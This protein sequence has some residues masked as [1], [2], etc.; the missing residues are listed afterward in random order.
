MPDAAGHIERTKPALAE[1]QWLY[2]DS[3]AAIA[4]AREAGLP[5]SAEIVTC[6]PALA[7]AGAARSLED[8]VDAGRIAALS[9]A[10]DKLGADLHDRLRAIPALAPYAL[11]VA[12]AAPPFEITAYK[13]ML[14]G[15]CSLDRPF[16]IA[17]PEHGGAAGAET[18]LIA[19][20]AGHPRLL[21]V[22]RVPQD[23]LLPA[24]R[25]AQRPP[26][27]LTRMRFEPRHSIGFRLMS[28]LNGGGRR[29]L[30]APVLVPSVNSLI[31]EAAYYLFFRGMPPLV[32]APPGEVA[33]LP[34]GELAE[35]DPIASDAARAALSPF[36][37]EPLA[38][39]A[40]HV[41]LRRARRAVAAYRAADGYWRRL[42]AGMKGGRPRA[43]LNNVGHLPAGDA[44][45]ALC[46]ERGVPNVAFQ[47]GTGF[48]LSWALDGVDYSA[49]GASAD[50]FLTF[51]AEA[52]A[53]A[54]R[55]RY[56]SGPA[57]AI[58]QPRDQV[59]G[60]KRRAFRGALPPICYVSTQYF[61]ANRMRPSNMGLSDL[62]AV[63]WERG[64]IDELL[65]PL[66]HKV[67]Y[68][69]YLG[70]NGYADG[71]PAHQRAKS[72]SNIAFFDEPIDLRYLLSSIRVIVVTHTG[73][74]INWCLMARRP[75]VYLNAPEQSRLRPEV[76]EQFRKAMFCFDWNV[77]A[78]RAAARAFLSQPLDAID[79]AWAARA[80]ARRALVDRW[81]GETHGEAGRR[82]ARIVLD[83]IGKR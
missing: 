81:F 13:A 9:A 58:G 36:A 55:S 62:E 63:R 32:A 49:E 48:E 19:L 76:L 68:K 47:H 18:P 54:G 64:V 73:S 45:F 23:R 29:V 43:V 7:E 75:L 37:G 25:L 66:P 71:N 80:E 50:R 52:A 21:D 12:R 24:R 61:I 8:G 31:K 10:V 79:R 53:R 83:M 2:A 26:G 70:P 41:F 6:S 44:L 60:V 17:E 59:E 14:I 4:C 28:R 78:E 40:A 74:T 20:L 27:L 42:F 72:C 38:A 1:A 3:L 5:P 22:L 67:L 30:G 77:P 82:A 35:L 34:A 11:T 16:A 65:A 51:S 57:V 46:R 33:D 69:P 15:R 39:R 56:A